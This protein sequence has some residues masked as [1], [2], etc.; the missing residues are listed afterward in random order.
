MT[1]LPPDLVRLR[2]LE[3]WLVLSLDRVR[4]RIAELERRERE[5]RVGE[6]RRPPTPAFTV[7][8]GIGADRPP[9]YVHVGGCHMAGQRVHAVSRG[10]AA[11]AVADGVE[12]CSHCRADT[13]LGVA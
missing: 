7:E 8:T 13:E 9:L 4:E 3:M 6:A 12:A 10:A 1:D 5:Q 2:T 11:Q